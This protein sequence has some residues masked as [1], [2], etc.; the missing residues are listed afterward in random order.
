MVISELKQEML[1]LEKLDRYQI[2]DTPPEAEF[3]EL[4]HLAAEIC[5]VPIALI[6]FVDEYRQWFKAKVGL[7][8]RE[9][10]R[11]LAFCNHAIQQNQ[12]L[13]VEN[14]LLDERF[15]EN[16]LVTNEPNIRFYAG[17]VLSTLDGYNL[18]TLCVID[19]VPRQLTSTQKNAL[20]VLS[21]QVMNQL[22]LRHSH[23]TQQH[24]LKDLSDVKF[25]L[26]RAAIVAI[27]NREGL[28]TYVNAK[29]CDISGYEREELLGQ[30]YTILDSSDRPQ[31]LEPEI[32]QSLRIGQ[33]WQGE[34]QSRTPNGHPYWLDT[35]I[36]PF[37]INRPQPD[38]YIVICHDITPQKQLHQKL[39]QQSAR[40][41]LVVRIAERIHRTLDLPT[42]L[43][44]TVSEIRQFLQ[45][46]RVLIY[47][48]NPSDPQTIAI[49]SVIPPWQSLTNTPVCDNYFVQTHLQLYVDGQI[50]TVK[51]IHSDNISPEYRQLLKNCQVQASLAVPI[52]TDN[53]Q[54][55]GFAIVHQCN[56][57][58]NWT[59]DEI[60]LLKE[61]AIHVAI[62]ISQANLLHQTYQ[63][64]ER[65]TT[66][67]RISRLLH[68][69]GNLE[70]IHQTALDETVK[71]LKS[72]GGRLYI[73]ADSTSMASQL[74]ISG[75]Q[76]V[77]RSLEEKELWPSYLQTLN[78][79]HQNS[80]TPT[81][82]ILSLEELERHP[83]LWPLAPGLATQ[84]VRSILLILIQYQQQYVGCLS[85][86]RGDR[87]SDNSP[88]QIPPAPATLWSQEDIYLAETLGV[89]LYLAVMQKQVEATIHHQAS[90]D[91]LTKLPNR[92]L[93][94]QHLA[95]ALKNITQPEEMLAVM[96]LDL[97]CFKSINDS[98]GHAIGDR[99]LQ[100]AAQRITH[101]LRNGDIVARWGGDEFTVI[102]PQIATP[103][104]ATK[105]AQRIHEAF[106]LPFHCGSY[107]LRITVSVGIAFAPNPGQD[108]EI[109]L[110]NA[111]TAMY[112]AKQRGRNQSE[113]YTSEMNVQAFDRLVLMNDLYRALEKNELVLYYQ[114][115]VNVK[116][117]ITMG[118]E[119]LIR[120]QHPERGLIP[121]DR[122]I[123]IAEETGQIDAI[124]EWV[125]NAACQQNRAWQLSGLPPIRMAINI[126]G[127]QFQRENF[128][129]LIARI[130]TDT[131]LDPQDLEIEIT[132]SIAMQDIGL[133]VSVL[134]ELSAM[135]VSIAID[136][137]GTGYSSLATLK[138]F[139]LHTLKIAR[140]FVRDL[141]TNSNDVAVVQT[142]IAL[143][144]GLN[145][146]IVAEGVE[147][148]EQLDCLRALNCDIAQGY[149]WSRPLPKLEM[150]TWLLNAK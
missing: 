20:Q 141:M 3:D 104:N 76:P 24:L 4:V 60:D 69:P 46:D 23:Q 82:E 134:K 7:T 65:E 125:M 10:D 118:V 126:S 150:I 8:A 31:T 116:T 111:D 43:N 103:E 115:Q 26:D 45:S 11:D 28:I 128:A 22:E 99:L 68:T 85:L 90:H 67:N 132:E 41:R 59:T 33:V 57:P 47:P 55:W 63:Q 87:F 75:E 32:W 121:P 117:G 129:Q 18:G 48:L 147:D 1:R 72:L 64:V 101:C 123:P 119:A 13:I 44:T 54:L 66:I 2:L 49:E 17:F 56:A 51:N 73:I 83:Q 140:E 36:V 77:F 62:A 148:R 70:D 61:L 138:Q 15:A 91:L 35:T 146:D 102:L 109:L 81:Y 79:T 108:A 96:F 50:Q 21:R 9:T 114:P 78:H 27:A 37:P 149:F 127:R 88:K 131:G 34:I 122:F 86:F 143:G 19:R 40:E 107:E 110:K 137:F 71:A 38:Q 58:R 142:I 106:I 93:F 12:P 14:A 135:G 98:L 39:Q 5:Q 6:S 42:I 105:I 30:L 80:Q 139:P 124:G 130:L 94:D 53:E 113:L 89:H 145:L 52:V 136:D 95:L 25:A 74:Y 16:P 144:H 97:D 84:E 100:Q 112:R 133:T 120:W 29:F 92:T